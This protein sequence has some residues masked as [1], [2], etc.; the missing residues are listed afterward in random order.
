ML[1]RAHCETPAGQGRRR[2]GRRRDP[3]ALSSTGKR[4]PTAYHGGRRLSRPSHPRS[5][6]SPSAGASLMPHLFDPF[7][8]R[9]VTLPNRIFVSPMCQYSSVGRL[10]ERLAS[11][12]PR[13][14]RRRRRRRWCSPR[15]RRSPPRAA[16]ARRTWASGTTSTSRRW[17]ASSASSHAQGARAGH[18]ARAR[19]P[20]GEHRAGRGRAAARSPRTRAAGSRRGRR[21]R[22]RSPT[23]T[24]CRGRSTA[25][26]IAARSSTRS[27]RAA[28]RALAAGFD[29]VEIHAAHGYLIHE[30]LS[31]LINTR[32]DDYGG[33]FENRVAA[34]ALEVVDAVRAVWPE[35]AAAVRPHL[36]DRLGGGRL[37]HRA[38]GRAGARG[39]ATTASI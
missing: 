13:Q 17:R 34:A 29:V 39:C 36:G 11:R 32:D 38:V 9:G 22:C 25:A 19:G 14:P 8:V 10:R 37:G 2:R 3:P 35:R 1:P 21:A 6:K 15:R 16:S 26:D 23:A 12:A 5:F 24:R 20:Q 18:A 30:F 4:S 7:S 28:R 27:P 33:S 31:P